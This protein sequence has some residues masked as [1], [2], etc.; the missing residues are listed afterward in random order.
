MYPLHELHRDYWDRGFVHEAVGEIINFSFD[1][2]DIQ[3]IEAMIYPDNIN[4]KKSLE[5]L[6]FQY[7]GLLRNYVYFRNKHQDMKMYSLIR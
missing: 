1:N 3:R 6:G 2:L 4:S 7:E 5:S